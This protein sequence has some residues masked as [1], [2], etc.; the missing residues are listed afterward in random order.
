MR[1]DRF[2]IG[3]AVLICFLTVTMGPLPAVAAP[4]TVPKL[5]VDGEPV[6]L[7]TTLLWEQD[8]ILVSLEELSACINASFEWNETEKTTWVQKYGRVL[9]FRLTTGEVLK[10]SVPIN[11]PVPAQ[12]IN[13]TFYVPLRFVAETLG[14][15]V[16]WDGDTNEVRIITGER[17]T[18][19]ERVGTR[20]FGAQVAYVDHGLLWLLDGRESGAKP[21]R[22]TGDGY[23][24]LIGWSAD[25]TWLAYTHSAKEYVGPFYLWV[26]KNDGSNAKKVDE[27]PIYI[28]SGWSP[29]SASIAYATEQNSPDGYTS[30][31]TVKCAEVANDKIAVNTIIDENESIMIPGLTWYPDGGSLTVSFPRTAAQP[32]RLEQ[33]DLDGRRNLLY[34]YKDDAPID[35]EGIYTWAFISP[36]WSPDGKYLAYHV[37]MNSGSL[38]ADVVATGLFDK[39]KNQSINLSEGLQYPQWMKF[40]P[41]SSKLAYIAGAGREVQ[42]NKWLDM[43]DLAKGQVTNHSQ[44]GFVDSQPVW[45]PGKNDQLLFCRGPE[46]SISMGVLPGTLVPGQRI[47]LLKDN[48]TAVAVTCGPERTADYYPNP[49]PSGEQL[50]Y[51]RLDRFDQGSLYLQPLTTTPGEEVEILSGLRGDPG[52]YGNYYPLWISVHWFD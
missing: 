43:A 18:P 28:H 16:I 47:Y 6:G 4:K 45:L 30:R 15:A 49:S 44:R 40:S 29:T 25:G 26:V 38:T 17:H 50:L 21:I 41:D 48:E 34:T 52:Y 46:A 35:P 42:L 8:R 36:K 31:G 22:L 20:V 12:M 3:I 33:V 24:E 51:V 9:L 37:R 13:G 39:S 10:N 2:H 27:E 5:V 1:K 14:A 32:P 7:A 23:A 11:L 19:P